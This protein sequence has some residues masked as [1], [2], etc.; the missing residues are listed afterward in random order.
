MT[1][2]GNTDVMRC[3][4]LFFFFFAPLRIILAEKIAEMN[5]NLIGQ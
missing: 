2:R 3:D 5:C 4:A 1:E